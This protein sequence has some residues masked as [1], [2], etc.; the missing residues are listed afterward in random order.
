MQERAKP[1]SETI[2]PRRQR[3]GYTAQHTKEMQTDQ[4]HAS[5]KPT[6]AESGILRELAEEQRHLD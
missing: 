1:S 6:R 5:R 2:S 3:N 4:P